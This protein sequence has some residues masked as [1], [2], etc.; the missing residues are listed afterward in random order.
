MMVSTFK[1]ISRFLT[2]WGNA[3]SA[4]VEFAILAPFF[5][6]IAAGTF[7]VGY[8]IYS[9]SE[10]SAAVSAGSQYAENNASM[11]ASSP[12][13]LS[14][15]IWT[16]VNSLNGSGASAVNVNNSN[17]GTHCYCPS[18]SPGNWTWGSTVICGSTCSGG[19]V[20]GQFVTII[21]TRTVPPLF[22]TLGLTYDG[23]I[24]RSAIVE[25]R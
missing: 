1:A 25:T 15:N 20:S 24:S 21:A 3:G 14:G 10:V 8:L 16:I 4:A 5:M 17:D 7:D 6:I 18:G 12:G 22:P 23:T 13:T 11:V 19:G 2:A 9:A